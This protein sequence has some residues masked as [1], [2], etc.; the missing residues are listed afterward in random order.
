MDVEHEEED[1]VGI[2]LKTK[3]QNIAWMR[4]DA[5]EANGM[6]GIDQSVF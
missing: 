5:V 4:T 2:E 6:N 3:L 1:E